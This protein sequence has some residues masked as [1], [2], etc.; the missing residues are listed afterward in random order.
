MDSDF[1]FLKKKLGIEYD[2]P[3]IAST[4]TGKCPLLILA[5]LNI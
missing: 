1:E 3:Q 4:Q 5:S 2:L